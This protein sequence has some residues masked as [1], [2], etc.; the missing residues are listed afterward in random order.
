MSNGGII[1]ATSRKDGLVFGSWV[2]YAITAN[3]SI[4]QIASGANYING[5]KISTTT[6]QESPNPLTI[7]NAYCNDATDKYLG[8]A[9]INARIGTI[10][11]FQEY[12]A[13]NTTLNEIP[14]TCAASGCQYTADGE[15]DYIINTIDDIL[16]DK[17]I[18]NNHTGSQVVIIAQ[19]IKI[20][21]SVT[22]IDALLIATGSDGQGGTIDTCENASMDALSDMICANPLTISGAVIA[23]NILLKRT[24]GGDPIDS[25][26]EPAELINSHTTL[27]LWSYNKSTEH[28][29]PKVVYSR[30][31]PPRY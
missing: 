15:R 22:H 5:A 27:Y 1:T 20:D 16:I 30:E 10:E 3:G 31:L 17:D 11:R 29:N 8:R 9:R 4:K 12:L 18:I 21:Q 6:C 2:D 14:Q 25:I 19:N 23:K 28:R 13:G 26:R 24:A 7:S